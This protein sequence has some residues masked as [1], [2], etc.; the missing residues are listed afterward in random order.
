MVVAALAVCVVLAVLGVPLAGYAAVLVA[1]AALV[2]AMK[3]L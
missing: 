3:Y 2:R 1:L